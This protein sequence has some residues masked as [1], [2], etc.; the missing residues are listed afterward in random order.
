MMDIE[1]EE[2]GDQG[3]LS[4]QEMLD[5]PDP[6]LRE[7]AKSLQAGTG[8]TDESAENTDATQGVEEEDHDTDSDTNFDE[9]EPEQGNDEPVDGVYAKDGKNIMPFSVVEA[10]RRE[11]AEAK[12]KLQQ[13]QEQQ[14]QQQATHDKLTR[15]FELARE[16]GV[17][18][19]VLPEDEQLT[20][21]QIAEL[22]DIGPEFGILARQLRLVTS[23]MKATGQQ[24]NA[25][26]G[27][28]NHTQQP[29]A[30]TEHGPEF[31]EAQAAVT[32]N[33]AIQEIL[34]NPNMKAMAV[35][36]E[37]SLLNDPQFAS[38][39]ARYA[40]VA[41]RVGGALGIDFG[42]KYGL[43]TVTAHQK[44]PNSIPATPQSMSDMPNADFA[45]TGKSAAEAYAGKSDAQLHEDL[46]GMTQAQIE[47]MMGEL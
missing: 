4:T 38:L 9:D 31:Y 13:L 39:D 45:Q 42:Q 10:A 30:Q 43:H 47:A 8:T 20:D 36:I 6:V 3:F 34:K 18:L 40:E 27:V 44:A 17:E 41:K 15:Q 7:Y 1:N 29:P 14:A 25:A 32:R 28:V 37:N 46:S 22:E 2:Y 21:E 12:Q 5:S 26:Q 23:N 33:P 35:Q 11:A 19:P 24:V 16:K